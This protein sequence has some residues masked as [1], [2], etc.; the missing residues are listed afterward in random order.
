MKANQFLNRCYNHVWHKKNTNLSFTH[1]ILKWIKS[2]FFYKTDQP[3]FPR[4]VTPNKEDW[5]LA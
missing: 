2:I 3:F 4:N 5:L 1:D